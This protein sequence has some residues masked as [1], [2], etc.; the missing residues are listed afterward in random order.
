MR[1]GTMPL[2][3]RFLS[4]GISL[5]T[6][7]IAATKAAAIGFW[8]KKGSRDEGAG[9]FG[10]THFL[11][12]MLFKGTQDLSASSLARF[13]DRIGGYVNAFTERETVC[14]FC[15][16][17]AMH[18]LDA[19][20]ILCRMIWES[21]MRDDEIERE[22]SVI[23]SEIL[24]SLDDPEDVGMDVALALMYPDQPVSRVIA[25]SVE[26]VNAITGDSLRAFYQSGFRN[27]VPLVSV[28]GNVDPDAIEAKLAS[29]TSHLRFVESSVAGN[30]A[31][32]SAG[33]HFPVSRFGQSQIFCS[34][35]ISF[36]RSSTNWFAWA[37][38]NAIIGNTVS[39]R[40]FQSL[41]EKKGL[42]YS[43]YSF[44]SFNRDCAIW[45]AYA[46]TPREKTIE[47]VDSMLVEIDGVRK[48]GITD[49]EYRDA[50]SHVI[51]EL[52][53]ASEDIENRMKRI[54]RQFFFNG[55]VLTIDESVGVLQG[56]SFSTLTDLVQ[57]DFSKDNESL[58]VYADKKS[59]KECSRRWR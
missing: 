28:A 2:T 37:L 42:C 6:E 31:V 54:A 51:G 57:N 41:R 52:E 1:L 16:V 27:S 30:K 46:A 8:F 32:W 45:S 38:I 14:V 19:M 7:P 59:A 55:E 49:D 33:R 25:G 18:A 26:D 29:C 58:I 11:E 43:V 17:P 21:V 50:R 35:P 24:S 4:N 44:Y 9:Q 22:R 53:L 15:V 40:L 34:Y 48:D 12:H 56:L 39:S 47:A 10:M 20:G 3:E 36:S 23:E 13:F 5:I